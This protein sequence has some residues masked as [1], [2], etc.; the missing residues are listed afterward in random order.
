MKKNPEQDKA[1]EGK[2][3]SRKQA[4][5]KSG[6]M[7]LSAATMMMLLHDSAKGEQPASPTHGPAKPTN[8]STT[9]PD[10]IWND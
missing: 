10:G 4:I 9:K 3:I 8:T 2:L 5:K 1:G 6:Y 7:A